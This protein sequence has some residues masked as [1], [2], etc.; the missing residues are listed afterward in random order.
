M[1]T[2]V[3]TTQSLNPE[4]VEQLVE[5]QAKELELKAEELALQK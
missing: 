3:K 4:I 2:P 1:Q 5:N